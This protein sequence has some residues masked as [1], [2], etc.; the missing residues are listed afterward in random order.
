MIT[1]S[2]INKFSSI[3]D[4]LKVFINSTPFGRYLADRRIE[5]SRSIVFELLNLEE[6][7]ERGNI[8]LAF[9][10]NREILGMIGF[11]LSEWD[12]KVFLKRIALIKYFL[13][14][15]F[16]A[17][18]EREIANQLVLLFHEWTADN[19]INAVITKLDTQYFIPVLTL[20]KNGYI[21]YECITFRSVDISS[22]IMN[23]GEGIQYRFA[24]ESDIEVLKKISL[25]NTFRKSHFYLDPNFNVE[26]V[27]LMYSKWI[28]NALNSN[29]KIVIIE[30]D[31]QIAGVFIYDLVDYSSILG[32]KYGIWESAYVDN[33]FR[34]KGIGLKLFKATLQSCINNGVNIV[35]SE[36][37][38][39]N[40][41]SQNFHDKLGFR[42]VNTLYTFHKW[43]D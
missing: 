26:R 29:K 37:V 7:S 15:E 36:L 25:K 9:N 2:K 17:T 28:E 18:I 43:F 20:Q 14:K 31:N 3:Q 34:N 6:Y 27:N 11:H 33:N 16:D 13:I 5:L 10:D 1:Y 40:I 22:D 30:D 41:I 8:I 19:K 35:D 21:L 32:K 12:T 38:E 42:L 24:K 23:I 4:Q 39:K